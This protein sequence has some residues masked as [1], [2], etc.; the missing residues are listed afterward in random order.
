M[1]IICIYHTNRGLGACV[2]P[3]G[4]VKVAGRTTLKAQ[5][6]LA[7]AERLEATDEAPGVCTAHRQ[8]A[9]D[10]GY[11]LDQASLLRTRPTPGPK[12]SRNGRSAGKTQPSPAGR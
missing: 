10:N 4:R 6:L 5:A 1:T 2:G 9:A 7:L 12:R 11:L 3:V 8:R